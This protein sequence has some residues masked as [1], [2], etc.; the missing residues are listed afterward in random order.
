MIA[1]ARKL[2]SRASTRSAWHAGFLEMLPAIRA[3]LRFAFRDLR[4]E[5]RAE[6]MA[7]ATA[8]A[9]LVYA[10][11]FQLAKIDVAYPSALARFAAAQYRSGR[12]VGSSLNVND[13]SS[14]HAQRRHRIR[15]EQLDRQDGENGWK[16]ILVEDR[17]CTPA[18]LA[19]SRIDFAA[20][21]RRL[22]LKR[23]RIAQTLALGETTRRAA[24]RFGL[25]P[26]RISQLRRELDADWLEFHCEPVRC[27]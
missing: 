22:P 17:G 18:E 16:E 19:A 5:E 2:R 12:R 9:A 1:F 20:W 3:Q 15:V 10:R 4:P 11:L 26:G 6:A 13:V 21:L 24:Q 8:N 27:A 25:S 14:R 7:D 23:R